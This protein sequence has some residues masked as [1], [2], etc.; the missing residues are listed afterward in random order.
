MRNRFLLSLLTLCL[1]FIPRLQAQSTSEL[2]QVVEPP[3]RRIQPP[4]PSATVQELETQGDALREQKDFLDALDYYHAALTK[5]PK[6]G[7]LWNKTGITELQMQ[8][9]GEARKNFERAIHFDRQSSDAINNLGVIFYLLRKYKN[10]VREY[11]RAIQLRPDSA[12]FYSNLGAAYFSKKEFEQA[13][14]AYSQAVKLDPTVFERSSRSG[15]SAQMSSPEDRAHFQYV[16]AKLF[17]KQGDS[18]RSL[19]YLKKAMEEGYKQID[20]VYKDPE[21]EALRSDARFT[22]LMATRPPGIPE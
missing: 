15:I 7:R 5:T 1:F 14:Q 16:L 4:P 22:Q 17:A 13:T 19:E 2:A 11:E 12:S 6:D 8:H 20:D 3:V 9:F 21:F 10:A 18:D